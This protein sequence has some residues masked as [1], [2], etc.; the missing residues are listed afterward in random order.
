MSVG[1]VSQLNSKNIAFKGYDKKLDKTGDEVHTFYYPHSSEYDLRLELCKRQRNGVII[2]EVHEPDKDGNFTLKLD[3]NANTDYFYRFKLINPG[4][5][6]LYANDNGILQSLGK[7]NGSTAPF[8]QI[9]PGRKIVS[10]PGRMQLQMPDLYYPGVKYDG[11]D[12]HISQ[13]LRTK[14][15]STLRTHVGKL[16]GTLDGMIYMLPQKAKEGYTRIVGTP[17]TKDEISSHLYWTQNAYQMASSLGGLQDMKRFQQALFRN[18]INFVSD[19]ALVNEGLQGIHFTNLMKWGKESPFFYWFKTYNL[20]SSQLSLGVI[21]KNSKNVRMR[22]INSPVDIESN[23]V[24]GSKYNPNLPTIVQLYDARLTSEEQE[25]ANKVFNSYDKTVK[26]H[27]EISNYDD[28]IIPYSFEV[29]PT[30]LTQNIKKAGATHKGDFSDADIIKNVLSFSKF[31]IGERKDGGVELW[32]GNVD[33]TKLNFS[34]GNYDYD[35]VNENAGLRTK[36]NAESYRQGVREVQDY[37][38]LSGKYWAKSAA[39]VQLEYAASAF[40]NVESPQKAYEIM[41][42]QAGKILPVSVKDEEIASDKELISNVF[43][44]AYNLFKLNNISSYTLIDENDKKSDEEIDTFDDFLKKSIMNLPMESLEVADDVASI[45]SSGYLTKRAATDEQIGLTRFDIYKSDYPNLPAKYSTLYKRTDKILSEDIYSFAEKIISSYDE[46]TS[47]AKIRDIDG[48]I[49]TFGKYAVNAIAQDIT[50]YALLKALDPNAK[51]TVEKD[52]TLNFDNIDRQKLNIKAL[53]IKDTTPERESENLINKLEKGVKNLV[54]NKNSIS[55]LTSAIEKRLNGLNE[56]SF[57]MADM[58]IDRTESGM[59]LR[60]DA[61]KDIAAIDSVRNDSDNI[62]KIWDD[63]IGFWS[64]YVKYGVHAENPHAFSTAEITDVDKFITNNPVVDLNSASEAERKLLEKT[65]ITSIANYSYFFAMPTGIYSR[66]SETGEWDGFKLIN[67]IK[68]KEDCLDTPDWRDNNGMLFQGPADSSIHSYTFS[69]NHDKP[70]IL[71]VLGLDMK[72]Y[73]SKFNDDD[74]KKIAK[75]VLQLSDD[76]DFDPEALSVGKDHV[77]KLSAPAI[78]MG[79]RLMDVFKSM[80]KE[81]TEDEI[82]AVNKQKEKCKENYQEYIPENDS[83]NSGDRVLTKKE[84]SLINDA[85]SDLACGIYKGKD[86]E[87]HFNPDSFGQKPF[88]VVIDDVLATAGFDTNSKKVKEIKNIALKK[89]LAPAMQ[90]YRAIYKMLT[91]LPGD[92]TD[93]A[94]D[95]EGMTG[96]ESK[97]KNMTQQNRN[98]IRWEWLQKGNSDYKPFIDEYKKA[99]DNI[100]ALRTNPELSP[101]N[102]GHTVS[103]VNYSTTKELKLPG[104]RTYAANLRYNSEG[105]QVIT[106]FGAPDAGVD[107]NPSAPLGSKEVKI[108]YLNL[109][110]IRSREGLVAGLEKGSIFRNVD[111]N[112]KSY[113]KVDEATIKIPVEVQGDISDNDIADKLITDNGVKRYMYKEVNTYV[114]H[115]YFD[116]DDDAKAIGLSKI[117]KCDYYPITVGKKDDNALVLYKV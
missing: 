72:L 62:S 30:E 76:S 58:I 80:D 54:N 93:F 23:P 85:I 71:H 108:N 19:A 52:G 27:Y 13:A 53:D 104:E 99:M 28:A 77:I 36:K 106:I 34:Y 83:E 17:F 98:A 7:V 92:P 44:G 63:V 96:F 95:K 64:K 90:K 103:L 109:G 6:T 81:M 89:M 101:L 32:D 112:D 42:E 117:E 84:I 12:Y 49:T 82:K 57:M 111:K 31:K 100:M 33:I 68:A 113:Y 16:G 74:S 50:K 40:K 22:I 43:K 86:G 91:L 21:P 102:N 107:P 38:V 79:K 78:A 10:K 14:A 5:E 15:L 97:A 65:G 41:Q 73:H 116:N 59:G 60:V 70:R 114:L 75:E 39:D 51:I 26:N 56:Y 18:G 87:T 48:N 67:G 3:D 2:P 61:A 46:K 88:D 94:G 35:M 24:K 115:R 66:N 69:G 110:Q 45:L 4:K 47:G 37:A 11:S 105:K 1:K 25:K 55:E 9:F 8:N 29:D 20:D